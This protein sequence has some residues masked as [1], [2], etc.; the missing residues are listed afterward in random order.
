MLTLI[1]VSSFG[2]SLRR[3]ILTAPAEAVL[4]HR[5]ISPTGRSNMNIVPCPNLE[6]TQ[7]RPW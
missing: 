6:S 2:E 7:M 1:A 4:T 5:T 3:D